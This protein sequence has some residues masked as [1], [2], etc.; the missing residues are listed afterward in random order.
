MWECSW[1]DQFNNNVD[2]KNHVRTHF[3]V[4][5]PLSAKSLVQ[6]IRNELLFGYINAI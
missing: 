4:K 3:P 6:N 2:V 5:K 1:W